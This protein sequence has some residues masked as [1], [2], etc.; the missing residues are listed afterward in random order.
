MIV[1]DSSPA[2]VASHARVLRV[3]FVAECTPSTR[4]ISDDFMT[5]HLWWILVEDFANE[6]LYRNAQGAAFQPSP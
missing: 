2:G 5:T 4:F 1:A 3:L 6:A